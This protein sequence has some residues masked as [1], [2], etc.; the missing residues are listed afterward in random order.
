MHRSYVERMLLRREII[1]RGAFT[2][3]GSIP[4]QG[5]FINVPISYHEVNMVNIGG[6]YIVMFN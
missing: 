1:L 5:K 4:G 2:D 3:M 6:Y